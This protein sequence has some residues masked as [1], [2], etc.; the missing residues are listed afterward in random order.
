MLKCKQVS[1]ALRNGKYWKLPWHRRM[2]LYM[3]VGLCFVCG[4][5]NRQVMLMQ[6]GVR[7]YLR[8]EIS[9]PPPAELR[10]PA[11]ARARLRRALEH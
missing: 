4:K 7:E 11:E 9:D 10:L 6:D 3:H 5:Y 2:G 1:E 8:H